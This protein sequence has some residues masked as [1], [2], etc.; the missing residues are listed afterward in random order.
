[1]ILIDLS[2]YSVHRHVADK[3]TGKY[4]NKMTATKE[5]II[6]E[7]MEIDSVFFVSYDT[8]K[9]CLYMESDL[10]PMA[11]CQFQVALKL[12]QIYQLHEM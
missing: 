9:D 11:Q 8:Y 2:G 12:G 3:A 1:M 10:Q 4:R 5:F 7:G 6:S